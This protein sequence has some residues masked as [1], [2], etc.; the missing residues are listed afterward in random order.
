LHYNFVTAVDSLLNPSLTLVSR[1][2]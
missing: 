1:N 2:F